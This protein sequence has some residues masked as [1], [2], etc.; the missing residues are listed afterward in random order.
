[1]IGRQKQ[2]NA[3]QKEKGNDDTIIEGINQR[4]NIAMYCTHR[5]KK[6][7]LACR[8]NHGKRVLTDE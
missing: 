6:T 5:H 8:H 1:M 4:R 7:T 3:T 2:A